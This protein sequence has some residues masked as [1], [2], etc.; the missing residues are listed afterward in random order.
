MKTDG[1]FPSK[2]SA[3]ENHKE[4]FIAV[5]GGANIDICGRSFDPLIVGDSNPGVISMDLGGVGRN[6]AH[7]LRLLGMRVKLLTALG[8]DRFADRIRESCKRLEIDISCSADVEDGRTS[9]YLYIGGSDGDMAVAVSDMEICNEL[10][11]E[12]LKRN[13]PVLNEAILIVADTNIPAESM[14]FLA[15]D[16]SRPL[17]VDPVSVRKAETIR[18]IVGKIHTLKT[19]RLEAEALSGLR[20]AV[21]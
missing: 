13:R 2:T 9:V 17:F 20:I 19:N 7:A 10:N 8:H 1:P 3:E 18:P 14:A 4:Q 5:V 12:Y 6:I 21:L 15:N 16:C 11:P